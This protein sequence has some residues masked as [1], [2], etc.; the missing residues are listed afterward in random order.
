[1]RPKA[2][3]VIVRVTIESLA[4]PFGP[5]PLDAEIKQIHRTT[6]LVNDDKL[7]VRCLQCLE[8]SKRLTT[9]TITLEDELAEIRSSLSR[10][11][12]SILTEGLAGIRPPSPPHF[13]RTELGKVEISNK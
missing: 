5:S 2:D 13:D 12:V 9:V 1:M 6:T 10:K 7:I 8:I 11:K 4:S 3:R